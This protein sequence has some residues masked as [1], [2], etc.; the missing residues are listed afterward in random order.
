MPSKYHELPKVNIDV[1]LPD[2]VI[3]DLEFM[4]KEH[5]TDVG[6]IVEQI[7]RGDEVLH[8]E[9]LLLQRTI[10][11]KPAD[12][13]PDCTC[14]MYDVD[15]NMTTNPKC[16][17]KLHGCNYLDPRQAACCGHNCGLD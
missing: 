14:L 12:A 9:Y 8:E 5:K 7:L 3:D 10:R 4:A 13:P 16:E 2:S 6:D 17:C 15:N 11:L 1:D